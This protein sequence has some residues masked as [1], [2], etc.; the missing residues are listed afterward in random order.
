[1][2]ELSVPAPL[3]TC[4]LRVAKQGGRGASAITGRSPF[5]RKE[6]GGG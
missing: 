6:L 2:V 1:M 4:P 5:C 3:T